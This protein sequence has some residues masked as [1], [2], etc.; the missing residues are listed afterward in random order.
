MSKYIRQWNPKKVLAAVS[1]EVVDNMDRAGRYVADVMR[2]NAPVDR[3]ILK[4]D[5]THE[6]EARGNVVETRVGVKRRAF[7]AWFVERGTVKM[8]AHPFIRRAVF[9]NAA[10]ILRIIRGG[11]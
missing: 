5:I 9:E 4:S 7:W 3:G 10:E 2:S 6:I 8:A 1:G 11:R